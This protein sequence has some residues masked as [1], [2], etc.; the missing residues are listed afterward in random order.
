M[1]NTM[2]I[3]LVAVVIS[4]IAVVYIRHQHRLTFIALKDAQLQRDQ[5]N[6]EWRQLLLEQSTWSLHHVVEKNAR[7]KLGMITPSS[8]DMMILSE[9][10]Q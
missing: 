6:I 1:R 8:K 3:L 7:E 4:G 10:R 9:R 2:L 5:S